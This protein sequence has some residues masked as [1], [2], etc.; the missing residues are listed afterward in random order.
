[1]TAID[2]DPLRLAMAWANAEACGAAIQFLEGDVLTMPLPSAD[3]AF[4]DPSRRD[5]DRRFLDPARYQPPLAAVQAQFA[6]GFPL[7]AKIAPGVAQR[8]LDTFDAECEFISSAGELKE[9][10]LWFGE[11]K[12]TRRRATVLP[13]ASLTSDDVLV[14]PPPAPIGQFLF[15]PDAAVIRA[16][17][18]PLLCEQ[19]GAAPIDHGVA[20]LTGEMPAE[21]PFADC[22]RVE[23]A[24]PMHVGK[25]RDFFRERGVGRL[26]I[27]KRA[28][29]ADVN[30]VA[31]QLKLSGSD[32]RHVILTRS[33]GKRVAVVANPQAGCATGATS[34][35]PH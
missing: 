8:D 24:L 1:M 31:K 17:L 28:V 20:L 3:A 35:R 29:D 11:L 16:G 34:R 30:D 14:E 27:L 13:N 21:S 25:L 33:L 18:L 23:D 7:A 12:T 19:F 5:G 4:V 2:S 32:H 15:D 10:V 22:Y 26:T 6:P 9:C